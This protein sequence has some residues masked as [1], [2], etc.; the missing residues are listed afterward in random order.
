MLLSTTQPFAHSP[1]QPHTQWDGAENHKVW[2]L[3]CWDEDK[4]IKKQKRF[5][6]QYLTIHWPMPRQSP[7]SGSPPSHLPSLLSFSTMLL[8]VEPPFGQSESVILTA[9]PSSSSRTPRSLMG[10][11]DKELKC[12]WLNI[13]TAQQQ[14]KHRYVINTA[15]LLNQKCNVISATS[16]KIN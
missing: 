3:M 2:E 12:S 16:K 6:A 9:Y 15:L 5:T 14:L 11:Q 4:L 7:S 10:E 13:R 8:G 1:L